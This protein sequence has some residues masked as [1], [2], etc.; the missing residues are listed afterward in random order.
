MNTDNALLFLAQQASATSLL[1]LVNMAALS[2]H[3]DAL[4]CPAASM[5]HSIISV[6]C[7]CSRIVKGKGAEWQHMFIWLM[8]L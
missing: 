6:N 1:V 8:N 5:L 4:Q 2:P 3:E 7:W